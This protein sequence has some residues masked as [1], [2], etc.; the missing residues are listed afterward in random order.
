MDKASPGDI[1][2]VIWLVR[3]LAQRVE[4]ETESLHAASG[5]SA[6]KR[7][8]LELL[9]HREPQSVPQMAREKSVSRQNVQ[10]IINDL[11][12]QGL[13]ETTDNPAHKRSPLIRR[14]TKGRSLTNEGRAREVDFIAAMA[15]NFDATDLRKAAQA[16]QDMLSYF[17]NRERGNDQSANP[18]AE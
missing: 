2:S 8:I 9:A 1:Y 4:T 15:P 18:E 6:S 12:T 17:D 13:I 3:Q 7:A 14:S 10:I 16:L 11:A 5:L